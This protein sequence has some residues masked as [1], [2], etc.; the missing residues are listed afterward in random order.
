MI[1]RRL[2]ER[3]SRNIIFR[4]SLPQRFGKVSI[5]VSPEGGLRY[6][7][8]NLDHVDPELLE[9]AMRFVHK[10]FCVWDIGANVGLFS[11]AAAA[12]AGIDG[13]IVSIDA[14][15]WLTALIKKS[16][17]LNEGAISKIETVTAA[18]S[19]TVGF[20]RF[21]IARRAR[22]S[23]YL[24]GC[25]TS[26]SGGAR[27]IRDVKTTTLDAL[28]QAFPL[29][30]FIKIDVEGAELLVLRGGLELLKRSRPVIFCEV[31]EENSTAVT[32]ILTTELD[33]S[34]FDLSRGFDPL[35]QVQR[36]VWNT[37]AIPN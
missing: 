11:L 16:A 6:W 23:S 7:W 22:S 14:D 35:Q 32:E 8:P 2:L 20:S 34:L 36:A 30:N 15:C 10:S 21:H 27:K 33:Y 9:V 13:R 37:F 12:R 4:R 31:S 25:G 1:A 28:C 17:S 24:E 5:Y 3:V 19:D 18:V 29:P 26:Q